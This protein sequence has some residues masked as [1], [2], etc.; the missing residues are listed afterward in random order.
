MAELQGHTDYTCTFNKFH[1]VDIS[2]PTSGDKPTSLLSQP[3]LSSVHVIGKEEEGMVETQSL[4]T[5]STCKDA[6]MM[7]RLQDLVISLSNADDR[8]VKATDE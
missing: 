4:T 5:Q 6:L 2:V 7:S 1:N 8:I 3:V